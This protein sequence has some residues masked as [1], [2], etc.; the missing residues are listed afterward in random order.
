[1]Q[2]GLLAEFDDH[3]MALTL[4]IPFKDTTIFENHL[5]P[6]MLVFMG[7]ALTEYSQMSSHVA[8]FGFQSF[9]RV[10]LH[11]IVIATLTT[12]NIRVE[13][14]SKFTPTASVRGNSRTVIDMTRIDRSKEFFQLSEFFFMSIVMSINRKTFFKPFTPFCAI[15]SQCLYE[16]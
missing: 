15:F 1:M 4:Q 5:N 3:K 14:N 9:F 16:F 11:Y 2:R 7:K 10:V 8:W 12:S 13:I 6:V